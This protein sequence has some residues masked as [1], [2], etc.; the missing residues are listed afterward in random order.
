MGRTDQRTPDD[1]DDFDVV[2]LDI[3]D[4]DIDIDARANTA[5]RSDRGPRAMRRPS[6]SRSLPDDWQDFDYGG[7]G[8]GDASSYWR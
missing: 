5:R 3:E 7:S 4:D 6:L 8:D 1:V 2:D